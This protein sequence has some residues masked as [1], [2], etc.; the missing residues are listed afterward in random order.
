METTNQLQSLPSDLRQRSQEELFFTAQALLGF[1]KL[2][3]HLHYEMCAVMEAADIYKRVLMLVPRDHYKSTICTVSY[4]SWRAMRN[5]ND[6][7]LIVANT[8]TNAKRFGNRI[9]S[10]FEKRPI[11]RN[12]YPHLKPELSKRWN[13]DELCLPR[14]QDSEQATWTFAGWDTKTT[15]QHFDY[16]VFDDLVD[17]ETYESVELMAKVNARFEQ[18][19]SLMKPPIEDRP[20]IVV[21]NHWSSIDLACYIQEK[22]PEYYIYYRQAIEGGRPI[23]PE[24]FSMKWLLRKQE[25]DPF[26]FATQYMNNPTDPSVT[27]NKPIWLLKYTRNE[28]SVTV[29]P[30]NG[31]KS[32]EIPV[33][34]MSIVAAVDPRHSLSKT[35]TQKLTSRN[36][37]VVAGADPQGRRFVLDEY[38]E[39]SDQ[40]TLVKKMAEIWRKWE[41]YG[42]YKI[43]IESYGYQGALKPL[44]EEIWKNESTQPNLELLPR[45]TEQSKT[46]RIRGGYAFFR[47]GKA[48]SH[49]SFPAF[50]EEYLSF[51][52]GK[53]KDVG[54]AWAWCMHLLDVPEADYDSEDEAEI[55]REHLSQLRSSAKI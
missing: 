22:H 55:D 43:G 39:R 41:P 13:N 9:R 15:S 20:I 8:A 38:A 47:E 5:P 21:M 50:N 49:R 45:D 40:G 37:I 17:E 42:L 1:D 7:G 3:D 36:A 18:R 48:Y 33:R 46:T 11:L 14:D 6:T 26:H 4:P 19:E 32:V 34:R 51:P 28:N 30:S 27:E 23:F 29:P 52:Y 35:A 25:A 12:T 24:G 53:T 10:S 54:D 16:A 31:D 2:T 44:A